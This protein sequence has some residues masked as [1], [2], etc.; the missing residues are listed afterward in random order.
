M[1]VE[2]VSPVCK[3]DDHLEDRIVQQERHW[4]SIAFGQGHKCTAAGVNMNLVYAVESNDW[5]G[6]CCS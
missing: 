6:H 5:D 3:Q 4:E 1:Q 2:S